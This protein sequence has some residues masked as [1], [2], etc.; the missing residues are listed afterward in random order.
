MY[1][2]KIIESLFLKSNRKKQTSRN[3]INRRT[4]LASSA[5]IIFGNIFFQ[6]STQ[7][8]F[9]P[10]VLPEP[11]NI[12]SVSAE[13]L[14]SGSENYL[15]KENLPAIY[16]VNGRISGNFGRR[17]N[18]FAKRRFENHFG[19]DIAAPVGTPVSTTADGKVIFAG[20]QRGYGNVVIVDH[21]DGLTTRYGH[22]SRIKTQTGADMLRGGTIGEVGSTGRSTGAHLHYEVRVANIAVDPAQYLPLDVNK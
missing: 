19:L 22:L 10:S 13:T 3:I 12:R 6:N 18:P 7:A 17:A 16:P 1:I 5:A 9:Q 8:Q 15:I 11:E 14:V 21:G 4:I 2:S 20:W